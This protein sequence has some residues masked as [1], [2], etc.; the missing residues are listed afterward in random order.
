MNISTT[1][2]LSAYFKDKAAD[3]I[4]A[5]NVTVDGGSGQVGSRLA[6][7]LGIS[8]VTTITKLTIEGN[9]AVIE[10][11]AE[12]DVETV[13]TTLPLLVTCQQGLK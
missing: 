8:I 11:D 4:L 5:G 9:R 7:E 12:G 1:A 13:E 6:E 3:I 2:I 10:R